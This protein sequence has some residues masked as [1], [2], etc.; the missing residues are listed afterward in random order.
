LLIESLFF[1]SLCSS[2]LIWAESC[3]EWLPLFRTVD[4]IPIKDVWGTALNTAPPQFLFSS[5]VGMFGSLLPAI[6]SPLVTFL[7]HASGFGFPSGFSLVGDVWTGSCFK[8]SRID[9]FPFS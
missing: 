3:L 2:L 5:A 8:V 7:R 4:S 9:F 1:V 6:S